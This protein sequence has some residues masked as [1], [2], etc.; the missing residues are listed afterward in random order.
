MENIKNNKM[1]RSI[2]LGKVFLTGLLL[3]VFGPSCTNLDEELYSE[4]TPDNF[5]QNEEQLVAALGEAYGRLQNYAS[6]DPYSLNEVST[7][8]IVVPTRG[9]DWDDGGDWR[10]FHLHAWTVEN[11]GLDGA[12]Q[13][14][15]QGVNSCNRLIAQFQTLVDEG[16]VEQ[17]AADAFIAELKVLR[18]FY[19]WQ[20]IN[21]FGDVPLT[22]DFL[23]AE[24]KPSRTPRAEVFNTIV[25]ELETEVPKLPQVVDG[26]TYGR[27]NYYAGYALLANMYLNAEVYTGTTEWQKASDACDIIIDD[28]LY[29]LEGDYFANFN[30]E[31]STS[32]EF[33]FAIPYDQVFFREFNIVMRTLHY[34]S[35]DTYNLTAQPWNGYCTLEEFYNSYGDED[36]RK[37]GVGTADEP[38]TGRGNFLAGYQ[39]KSDGTYV[40]DDGAENPN[41]DRSPEPLLGDPEGAPL[42]FGNMG[43]GRPQIHEL[44]PQALRQDGIRIGKW[45]F[46]Q[47]AT[48][49]LSNDRAV[50]RYGQI[51]LIKAECEWQ[52]GN[53]GDALIL[54]NQIRDRANAGDL[55]SLDGPLSFDV[56]S[57]SVPGGELFNE[58]GREMFA[59][60]FRRTDL[61]RWG[62]FTDVEKWVIPF[63]NAGDVLITDDYTNLYPVP[64]GQIDANENLLPNND[65]YN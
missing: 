52:L 57:G 51:L 5:F 53:A 46:A 58:L 38:Y 63:Y 25:S 61:I 12:W 48:E 6:N 44:G 4:V 49:N 10:R 18:G 22:L 55:T 45:Q 1:K 3:M 28:G 31:N 24:A 30:T 7:D 20:L 40:T 13:F 64:R 23:T 39:Y 19:Y 9:Q 26:T 59:E 36:R 17:E 2:L 34:G 65:G 15:F 56:E 16:A 41:P 37:G 42:N 54:V 14:G 60:S 32:S 47:G 11:G 21:W 29:S 62:F 33:I 35:Q 27:M 8:E 50:F 43:T